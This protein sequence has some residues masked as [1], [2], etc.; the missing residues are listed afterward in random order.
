M[1]KEDF[2]WF[3]SWFDSPYYHVLY[4]DRDYEEAGTFI[5]K[6]TSFLDLKNNATV[7]DLACGKGRHSKHLATLGYNVTGV[8][9]SPNSIK[10][11]KAFETKN[12][13]FE[14][15]DMCIAYSGKFDAIF[16]LFTSFGYF[17]AEIDNLRTIKA[18]KD[19]L[20][21]NGFGIIDFLNV[22]FLKQHLVPA[23]S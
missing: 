22:E 19:S 17:E 18:I 23:S 10:A 16:N 1:Q 6:L 7:L 3:T 4:K 13:K 12:L 14:I 8:D 21:P 11:A 15:H 9:L 5:K 2:N 20:K